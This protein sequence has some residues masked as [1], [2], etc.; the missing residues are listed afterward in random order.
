MKKA[1]K[2]TRLLWVVFGVLA[3]TATILQTLAIL[4]DYESKTNYFT[5]RF[6]LP[7][8]AVIF[9]ILAAI[10]GSVAALTTKLSALAE[11]PFPRLPI[12]SLTAI[13]SILLAVAILTTKHTETNPIIMP[14]TVVFL[15][16]SAVYPI[17][18]GIP[19]C[20]RHRTVTLLFGMAAVLSCIL[21][22]AY[23]YFDISVEMNAPLKTTLQVSLLFLMLYLTAELRYLL[24]T[25][26]P[27]L[28]LALAAWAIPFALISAIPLPF[29]LF[30]GKLTRLDYV[31]GGLLMLCASVTICHRIAVLYRSEKPVDTAAEKSVRVDTDVPACVAE[32]ATDTSVP[33]TEEKDTEDRI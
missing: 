24:G 31:A 6:P 29:A 33:M 18:S 23:Y 19:A 10:V 17:L 22:N 20:R 26:Q 7:L 1:S 28:Y 9:A 30:T 32:P 15:I 13:G 8:L 2:K 16:L 21:T 11:N 5:G 25:P 14:A 12:P 4:L 3:F 27:R